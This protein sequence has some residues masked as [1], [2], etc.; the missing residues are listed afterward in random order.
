MPETF[1]GWQLNSFFCEFY[2]IWILLTF[3]WSI[4]RSLNLTFLYPLRHFIGFAAVFASTL[5][6]KCRESESDNREPCNLSQHQPDSIMHPQMPQ[7]FIESN[8]PKLRREILRLHSSCVIN[9][10]SGKQMR[11]QFEILPRASLAVKASSQSQTKSIVSI[12]TFIVVP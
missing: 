7:Q 11:R 8:R 10:Q 4:I 9:R 6:R 5:L 12:Y 1:V 2:E 3:L